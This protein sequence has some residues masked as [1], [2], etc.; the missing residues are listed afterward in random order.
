MTNAADTLATGLAALLATPDGAPV[1]IGPV[2]RLSGGA[3][4]ETWAFDATSTGQAQPLILRRAPPGAE[5]RGN[6]NP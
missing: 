5:L 3:S 1:A 4:Q 6:G 2:T